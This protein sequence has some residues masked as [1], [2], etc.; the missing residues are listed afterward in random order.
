MVSQG[1]IWTEHD[2]LC[3]FIG[4]QTFIVSLAHFIHFYCVV[5]VLS[6]RIRLFG[7]MFCSV[8]FLF[9]AKASF[10]LSY[11]SWKQTETRETIWEINFALFFF[12]FVI[13]IRFCPT[14]SWQNCHE[15]EKS[16]VL[17]LQSAIATSQELL[18][19]K[20]I[21]RKNCKGPANSFE[22]RQV[23]LFKNLT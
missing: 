8:A 22:Q 10:K 20:N 12:F 18:M 1:V 16:V 14:G 7:F 11:I 2:T 4:N 9:A 5:V 19:D 17:F 13:V 3:N 15:Q 21:K 23:F 6:C